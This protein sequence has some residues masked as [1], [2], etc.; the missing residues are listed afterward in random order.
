MIGL[1]WGTYDDSLNQSFLVTA[2][3][4][5]MS[6]VTNNDGYSGYGQPVTWSS[7]GFGYQA[8]IYTIASVM[9]EYGNDQSMAIVSVTE[10][11][12]STGDSNAPATSVGVSKNSSDSRWML[13]VKNPSAVVSAPATIST[14]V[15]PGVTI[16]S[17]T[18]THHAETSTVSGEPYLTHKY[19]EVPSAAT[20]KGVVAN[21]LRIQSYYTYPSIPG[22]VSSEG[23][24]H[25]FVVL[26]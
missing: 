20:E 4:P 6:T 7:T 9:S 5:N 17:K 11:L 2:Y 26:S 13:E 18:V 22:E 12:A 23:G 16:S 8:A 25:N 24:M 19:R 21:S 3:R 10:F 15:R 1:F 14:T